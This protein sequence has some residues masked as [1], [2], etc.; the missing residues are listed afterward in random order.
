MFRSRKGGA[1]DPSAV[2]RVVKAAAARA[3]LPPAA[4]AHWLRHA[5]ASHALDRAAPIH[6]GQATLGHAPVA[7]TGLYLHVR[8]S[9]SSARFL[10]V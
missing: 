8:P 2:H 9:E 4:S 1:L 5:R 10:G 7:T 6:R 3:G